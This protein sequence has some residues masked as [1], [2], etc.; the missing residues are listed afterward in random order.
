MQDARL[1]KVARTEAA[2]SPGAGMQ[3]P[4]ASQGMPSHFPQRVPLT[5][6]ETGSVANTAGKVTLLLLDHPLPCM[7]THCM[8]AIPMILTFRD[9]SQE[10]TVSQSSHVLRNQNG[11][12][13]E[14]SRGGGMLIAA[15]ICRRCLS[16]LLTGKSEYPPMSA[17]A[18]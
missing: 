17:K 14:V 6:V 8:P 18:L 7:L 13:T 3:P 5:I 1:T 9:S 2:K 11:P 10:H 16:L 15:G 12:G 4:D